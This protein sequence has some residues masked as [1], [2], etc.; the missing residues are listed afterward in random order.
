MRSLKPHRPA[1]VI[2]TEP[3]AFTENDARMVDLLL[4]YTYEA[5]RRIHLQQDLRHQAIHDPLTGVYN[6]RYL[7]QTIEVEL[8]RS[9]RYDHPIGFLM[10]DIDHFKHINDTYGHQTGDLVLKVIADLLVEQV[11]D[12][13]LVVRYGGDEFLLVLIE[14]NGETEK[15]MER[16]HAAVAERNKTNELVPFPVTLSVG[17]AHWS[18]EL[19]Q[20][21]EEILA[22]AD[23]KMYEAKRK[24]N[25]E[26]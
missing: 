2:S 25:K 17:S 13:D 4:G 23:K 7:H 12:T 22:E 10:I 19:N 20:T 3:D 21:A 6:R 8:Q 11:R 24:Q 14:T 26:T 5:I 9:K 15:V 1:Q 18:P 16:I